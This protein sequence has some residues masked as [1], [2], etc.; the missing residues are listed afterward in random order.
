M[1]YSSLAP[2][3]LEPLGVF[4]HCLL[5]RETPTL[6]VLIQ[7]FICYMKASRLQF[8]GTFGK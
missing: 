6:V 4:K 8:P 7:K 5:I 1:V 3:Q 2:G